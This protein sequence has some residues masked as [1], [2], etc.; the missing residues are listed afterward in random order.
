MNL[1]KFGQ[2]NQARSFGNG[3]SNA[4][5]YLDFIQ[6]KRNRRPEDQ[7]REKFFPALDEKMLRIQDI[8]WQ[9]ADTDVPVL[10]TGESGSGKNT[11]AKGIYEAATEKNRPF[12]S[13]NCK[14]LPS[15]TLD[16][17]IF[18]FE[19]DAF[20]GALQ[21][22]PGRL[23]AADGGTLVLNEITELDLACQAKLLRFLQDKK[24]ERVGGKACESFATRIIATTSKDIVS[25]VSQGKFRQDLYYRLYV[26][27]ID[28]PPLRDRKKDIPLL[29]E[30]F[31]S[32]ARSQYDRSHMTLT[33]EA[34]QKLCD[35]SWP[36]NVRELE[37]IIQRAV[38]LSQEDAIRGKYLPLDGEAAVISTDWI[39]AL[40]LGQTLRTVETHFIL[41][42]LRYHQGNR[43]HA[44]RVLGI[45]LRTL[46]N[47]INEFTKEGFEVT[48]PLTG[49]SLGL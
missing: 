42:T 7:R 5:T 26:L 2:N 24:I 4:S 19:K 49:R 3:Y 37:N 39:T 21:N 29:A 12:T 28:T 27:H 16:A 47:K 25:L 44:A 1:S 34:I 14:S 43:T 6:N 11:I 31:L 23:A 46:R 17:E 15:Q 13:L 8:I 36:G 20:T 18:G 10:I 32:I 41:E 30:H 22:E 48:Q 9:I 45:S 33:D 35:H 40:P 38:I